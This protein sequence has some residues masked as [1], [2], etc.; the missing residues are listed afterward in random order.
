MPVLPKQP[1]YL[2]EMT[3]KNPQFLYLGKWK[4]AKE[5]KELHKTIAYLYIMMKCGKTF[6]IQRWTV[7]NID[8][9]SRVKNP[10]AARTLAVPPN[11]FPGKGK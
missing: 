10:L 7:H 5:T 9:F 6:D 2:V 3:R 1:Q 4:L 8:I 11:H